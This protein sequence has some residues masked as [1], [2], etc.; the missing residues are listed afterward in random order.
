[1]NENPD[2]AA[3]SDAGSSAPKAPESAEEDPSPIATPSSV[4]ND[5]SHDRPSLFERLAGLFKPRNGS[6]LRDDLT[7]AL[8]ESTTE[9]EGF[10]PGERAMLNNILR[11]REVRVEDVMVP[12]ADIEAVDIT[13]TLGDLMVVFEKSGHSRMPV[14]SETLDDPRGMVHIRDVLA[15]ITRLARTRKGRQPKK[16]VA[17]AALDF[18]HVDLTRTIGDLNLIR[19]VLF[20]PPSMLA[21]DLMARMQ[22][23]RTQMALVIDEYGGTDGLVSLEDIVEMVVG[24]IEDEHDEEEPLITQTADGVFVVDA[25][26]EIDDVAKMIGEDFTAGEHGEYVDTIGGMIFNTLGRVPTRG[27][28]VQAIPGFE[29]HV[30]DADPRRVKRVR[31]VHSQRG[32]RRRRAARTE[33]A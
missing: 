9:A 28:V 21:S 20:V 3:R 29:F 17:G 4:A 30:L 23:S 25:R 13:T 26:A 31:I 12:R 7:D 22:A 27:E 2:T 24:D 32:E 10:S 5:P 15:H 19:T 11:L 18:A 8:A 14:Y 16:P 6:S 33:Q 1:M